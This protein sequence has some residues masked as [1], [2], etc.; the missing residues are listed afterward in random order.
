MN[1]PVKLSYEDDLYHVEI[2]DFKLESGIT[3]GESIEEALKNAKEVIVLELADYEANNIEFPSPTNFLELQ[4]LVENNEIILGVDFDY[5]YEKSL[6]KI[7]YQKKTLSIPTWLDILA[8]QKN[9]NF[10]QAL[11][12]AL[13]EELGIK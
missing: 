1:Y 2:P 9:I 5:Y 13:K 12:K 8:K 3:Y 11:Q 10:S 7:S 4:K 6:I